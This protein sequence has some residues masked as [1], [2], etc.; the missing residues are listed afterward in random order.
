MLRTSINIDYAFIKPCFDIQIALTSFQSKFTSKLFYPEAVSEITTQTVKW[1][2]YK[3]SS[4]SQKATTVITPSRQHDIWRYLSIY[5]SS[6]LHSNHVTRIWGF[7]GVGI[8]WIDSTA[9]DN[10]IRENTRFEN[11]SWWSWN[12]L[13]GVL[14]L[15]CFM[16]MRRNGQI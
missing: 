11:E 14:K 15:S 2:R 1:K 5:S 12:N 10:M 13:R 8:M 6:H 7:H 16:E 4:I 3:N 9:Q